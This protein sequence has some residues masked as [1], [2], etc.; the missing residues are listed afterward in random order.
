MIELYDDMKIVMEDELERANK[1]F[2]MFRSM[3][4]GLG[5]IGEE[6]YET[7]YEA[8]ELNDY[9]NELMENIFEDAGTKVCAASAKALRD[10][11]LRAACETIQV[12]AMAQKFIDSVEEKP[13]KALFKAEPKTFTFTLEKDWNED[14]R[15]YV[16]EYFKKTKEEDHEQSDADRKSCIRY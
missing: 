3:H 5:I 11:S 7:K 1:K 6:I 13:N 9:A 12:A 2:P 16:K 14:F 15:K 4:E 8:E 10:A